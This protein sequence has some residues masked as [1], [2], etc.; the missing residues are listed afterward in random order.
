[1]TMVDDDVHQIS[2]SDVF[3][4]ELNIHVYTNAAKYGNIGVCQAI[5][6]AGDVA[7]FKDGNLREF[8]FQNSVAGNNTTIVC[9]ATLKGK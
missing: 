1:M 7:S 8:V 2:D 5:I 9:I 6:N 4:N 3:F